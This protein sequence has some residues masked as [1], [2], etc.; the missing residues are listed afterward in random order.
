MCGFVA[1]RLINHKR[2]GTKQKAALK[3]YLQVRKKAVQARLREINKA[4]KHVA[5]KPK[6]RTSRRRRR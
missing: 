1:V 5:Q 3:K 4:I 2:L 6:R